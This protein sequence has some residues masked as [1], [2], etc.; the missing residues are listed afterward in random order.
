M[1]GEQ[2]RIK[3]TSDG[4]VITIGQGSL[5]S[6]LDEMQ[7]RLRTKASFFVG[8]RVALRVGERPLTVDQIKA[9]GTV[10]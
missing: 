9:I 2:V 5:D 1:T 6:V 4:L 3:G 7:T 10:L 8:G